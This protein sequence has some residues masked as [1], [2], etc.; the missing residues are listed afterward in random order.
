MND[1]IRLHALDQWLKAARA[2]MAICQNPEE[3]AE[4]IK[5]QERKKANIEVG[6]VLEAQAWQFS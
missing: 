3:L 6:W 1:Q 2:S 4:R 5:E